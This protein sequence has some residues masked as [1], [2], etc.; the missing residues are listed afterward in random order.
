MKLHT[1][2]TVSHLIYSCEPNNS[3]NWLNHL[4]CIGNGSTSQ[5]FQ[6]SRLP[7]ID[8][9]YFQELLYFFTNNVSISDCDYDY[10]MSFMTRTSMLDSQFS[11]STFTI[12]LWNIDCL[13]FQ[14]WSAYTFWVLLYGRL[15]IIVI[16]EFLNTCA[17][18]KIVYRFLQ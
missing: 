11:I 15:K 13:R 12:C 18:M 3:V 9:K 7:I 1:S 5:F 16:I 4:M 2:T 8:W 17:Q 14:G 6:I 10:S